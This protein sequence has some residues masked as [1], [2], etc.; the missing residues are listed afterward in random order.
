MGSDLLPSKSRRNKRRSTADTSSTSSSDSESDRKRR[1]RSGSRRKHRSRREREDDSRSNSSKKRKGKKKKREVDDDEEGYRKGKRM[2]KSTRSHKKKRSRRVET[3]S[4]S[5]DESSEEYAVNE[6]EGNGD[7]REILSMIL[8]KFPEVAGDLEKLLQMVDSGQAVD[9]NGIPNKPLVKLLKELFQSLKLKEDGRL[10][11][12]PPRRP[13]TLEVVGQFLHAPAKPIKTSHH[14]EQNNSQSTSLDQDFV[15]NK[16]ADQHHDEESP[17]CEASA[18]PRRRVIGPEMPSSALLAAAAELTEA[19]AALRGAELEVNDDLFIGPPP[20]AVA[21]EAASANEA[22]RF[23]EVARIMGADI[24]KPYDV[25]GM[26]Y[27]MAFDNMKKRYWKLSLMVH[28]DKC[29]HPQA[30]QAFVTLNKAFKELQDPDKRK[31]IDDKLR[32]KEEEEALKVELRSLREAAQ[33]RKLQ[34]ISMEGDDLLLAE[35]EKPKVRDE[36]MT[37]LPPERKPGMATQSTTSFSRTEKE[38]RG[39][40]SMWTNNPL[41]KTAQAKQNYLE[42]LNKTTTLA[43]ADDGQTNPS[44]SHG[45][46]VDKYNQSKRSKSLVQKHQEECCSSSRQR[47]KKD[48]ESNKNREGGE[49][50]GQHPWRPWDREKDLTAG[51]QKVKL[52]PENMSQGLA[53]RFSGGQ[54]QRNFL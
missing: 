51:R 27:K 44:N 25:L 54:V 8:D 40:T 2:K 31:E 47:K 36:W 30:N 12:L 1:R 34:G 13:P 45:D 22:E 38:G 46:L 24:T 29:P 48:K 6:T 15:K 18:P 14:G 11:L 49:W 43:A 21:A 9:I 19:E 33:W 32:L 4:S 7:S 53:S 52:D 3:S 26:N 17:K 23:E 50:V 10:F 39:D 37:K 35:T 5:S 16:N 41:E 20:P 28:P 42:A